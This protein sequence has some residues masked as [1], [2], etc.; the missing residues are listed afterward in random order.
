ME[1][2]PFRDRGLEDGYRNHFIG[3][4]MD[5]TRYLVCLW[6]P[7][8]TFL[9]L[10][11]TSYFDFEFD[12]MEKVGAGAVFA[13]RIIARLLIAVVFLREWGNSVKAV[14][15][16]IILWVLRMNIMMSIVH[17]SLLSIVN[18]F[19]VGCFFIPSFAEYLFGSLLVAYAR[20]FILSFTAAI[21][22]SQALDSAYQNTLVLALGVSIAWTNHSDCRR[23]FLRSA[24]V[25]RSQ[26]DPST[27]R[28]KSHDAAQANRIG[29]KDDGYFSIEDSPEA[30]Q[31]AP[32]H[33]S[34]CTPS[35]RVLQQPCHRRASLFRFRF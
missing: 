19:C 4:S 13:F 10:I 16:F 20:L 9:E 21:E 34:T 11:A 17:S 5:R 31:V 14:F 32:L 1:P 25:A 3:S 2:L 23:N 12:T 35:A 33:A 6:V 7:S 24:L 30:N 8:T 27:G 29:P 15:G 26:P 18:S 28:S 22:P